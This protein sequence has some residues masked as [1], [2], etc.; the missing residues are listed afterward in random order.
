M[1]AVGVLLAGMVLATAFAGCK[2]KPKTPGEIIAQ[3]ASAW[4]AWREANPGVRP[5]LSG[6]VLDGVDLSGANLE[7]IVL[8]GAQLSRA[9]LAHAILRDTNLSGA[10][11]NQANL[12]ESDLSAANL[13][14][15]RLTEANLHGARLTGANLSRADVQ[16][17]SLAD[18]DLANANIDAL[19]Q[20]STVTSYA[21][22][23]IYRVVL[24]P[25]GFKEFAL[26][27]GAVKRG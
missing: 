15:A 19:S 1:R 14:G 12:G 26:E 17:A 3:G 11:L 24:A 21:G 10:N 5:D 23:N 16:G 4:N 18:A 13:A 8:S 6:V 27:Q 22:A 25:A 7:G 20:W 2:A 9:N